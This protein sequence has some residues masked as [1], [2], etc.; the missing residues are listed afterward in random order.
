MIVDRVEKSDLSRIDLE[1]G[2]RYPAHSTALG[3]AVLAYLPME[4]LLELFEQS[5]LP[6]SSPKTIDS[7]SALLDELAI[8]RRQGYATSDG[9]L[10]LGFRAI[11]APIFDAG[12]VVRAAVSAT[13]VAIAV[14]DT[15]VIRAV[16]TAAR[17]I[18]LRIAAAELEKSRRR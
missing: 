5:G 4:Q 3:K 7:R 18:S 1:I 14:D 10:F 9:E 2:V 11:A 15:A 17:E 13:G 12:G 6:K 8:V 16:T